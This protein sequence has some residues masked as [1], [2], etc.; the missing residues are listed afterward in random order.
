M[1]TER[2]THLRVGAFSPRLESKLSER[3]VKIK[4]IHDSAMKAIIEI[5]A[6]DY[7][8]RANRS[9]LVDIGHLPEFNEFIR[10]VEAA[11]DNL[12]YIV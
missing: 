1:N 10:T 3:M 6:M 5:E 4:V 2:E 9:D 11:L 7:L 8:N 12:D